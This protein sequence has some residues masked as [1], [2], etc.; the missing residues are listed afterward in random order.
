MSCGCDHPAGHPGGKCARCG[1]WILT[2]QQIANHDAVLQEY[3]R[4]LFPRT[5]R[6]AKP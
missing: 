3:R 5:L 2:Q 4:L 1:D 6:R